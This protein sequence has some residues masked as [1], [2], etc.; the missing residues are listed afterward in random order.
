MLWADRNTQ[1]GTDGHT[2]TDTQKIKT[3]NFSPG[4]GEVILLVDMKAAL[5]L[6]LLLLLL[7]HPQMTFLIDSNGKRLF[8][9]ITFCLL[10]LKQGGLTMWVPSAP[11]VLRITE[12]IS[13]HHIWL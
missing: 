2:D 9:I 12:P 6:L 11:P 3:K 7:H 4:L 13:I 5:L 10:F 1:G 8:Q